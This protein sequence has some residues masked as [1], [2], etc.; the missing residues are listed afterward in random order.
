MI[1]VNSSRRAA[2]IDCTGRADR[3]VGGGGG[4]GGATR[5]NCRVGPC[6]V[7]TVSARFLRFL[8][9]RKPTPTAVLIGSAETPRIT[10]R[11]SKD[12]QAYANKP[13]RKIDGNP[14]TLPAKTNQICHTGRGGRPS[15]LD[16]SKL[17]ELLVSRCREIKK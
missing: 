7:G 8:I 14:I 11:S 6:G 3:F 5:M 2:A 10:C 16:A 4:G 15:L 9:S 1:H 17:D 13:G 12:R